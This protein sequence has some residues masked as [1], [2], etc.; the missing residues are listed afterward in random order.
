MKNNKLN[1]LKSLLNKVKQKTLSILCISIISVALILFFVS[2]FSYNQMFNSFKS[3]FSDGQFLEAN[4]ILLTKQKI[5]PTKH[6]LLNSS[7]EKYFVNYM[8]KLYAKYENNEVSDLQI[9]SILSE[10]ERYA[11]SIKKINEF[12]ASFDILKDSETAFN[13]AVKKFK[14][15]DYVGAFNTF[16]KVLPFDSN[17]MSVVNYK[18]DISEILKEKAF[19]NAEEL[20]SQKYYSK[21]ITLLEENMVYYGNDK[22]VLTKIDEYKNKKEKVLNEK[23]T[24][25]TKDNSNEQNTKFEDKVAET[26]ALSNQITT[27]NIN[28]LDLKS[29]SPYLVHVNLKNQNTYV[30][31]GSKNNWKLEKKFTCST[32]TKGKET[33]TG[34]YTTKSKGDWFY[35]P[36]YGQGGKYWVTF[37]DAYMFHSLPF[38]KDKKTIVDKTLGIPASHGCIRLAIEDA[39]WIYDNIPIGSK[40]IIN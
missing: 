26:S 34:V 25:K 12:K 7:L 23:S 19:K 22:D 9:I 27:A 4:K 11:P 39:K 28:S 17:Y 15:K 40:L 24:S 32:G 37:M 8:D 35:E 5:N 31:K 20:I 16:N 30:Y 10:M 21:A 13:L 29:D 33:P 2:I 18:Q 1:Y 36:K 38:A 14:D 3:T 6:I